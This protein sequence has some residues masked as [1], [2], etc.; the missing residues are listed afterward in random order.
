MT[1]RNDI[2]HVKLFMQI[3]MREKKQP[4]TI[5]NIVII[6]KNKTGIIYHPDGTRL[7]IMAN[8]AVLR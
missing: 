7:Y 5:L 2:I 3:N 4:P 1:D 6:T 8:I